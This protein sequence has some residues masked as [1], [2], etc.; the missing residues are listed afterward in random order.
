MAP[1]VAPKGYS[2]TAFAHGESADDVDGAHQF[3]TGEE[4]Q[5]AFLTEQRILPSR[6]ALRDDPLVTRRPVMATSVAQ[7]ER[8]RAMP[9]AVEMRAVWDAMR[10]PYQLLMAGQLD[11]EPAARR[12]QRD[13]VA[14]IERMTDAHRARPHGRR[15]FT[16][17]ALAPA[18]GAPASGSAASSPPFCRDLRRNRL[19]YVARAPLD[20]A[21][22]F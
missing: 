7:A 22:S 17:L 15:S 1:M 4:T 10:P 3:L 5:R 19:A 6:L 16:R 12:M 2:L 8:G 14:R 18:R 21:A 13:A 11:A 9:T 20:R